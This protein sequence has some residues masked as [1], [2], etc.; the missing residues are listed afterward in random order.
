MMTPFQCEFC[1]C[2]NVKGRD[3]L[4]NMSRDSYMLALLRRANL[5]AFWARQRSN[6]D[7]TLTELNRL[8]N[9]D[10]MFGMKSNI[11]P[12]RP[13]PTKDTFGA[14]LAVCMLQRSLDLGM[15]TVTMQYNT[16]R[17]L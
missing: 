16:T 6:L 15:N 3:A 5:N 4:E 12:R 9:M 10:I 1:H 11:P 7:R 8:R 13:F 17:K 14:G 2:Q